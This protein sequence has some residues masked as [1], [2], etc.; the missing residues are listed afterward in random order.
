MDPAAA[1]KPPEPYVAPDRILQFGD[2]DFYNPPFIFNPWPNNTGAGGGG[3]GGSWAKGGHVG[4]YDQGG[5]L[6][7]GGTAVNLSTRP[8]RVLTSE[9]WDAMNKVAARADSGPLVKIDAIYGMSPE[10]VANQIEAKQKLAAMRF[11]GRPY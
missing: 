6:E 7:P 4:V 2:P 1:A 11:T 5:I 3:G 8:E 10:D 9:Q